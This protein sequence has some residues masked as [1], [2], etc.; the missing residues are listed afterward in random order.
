MMYIYIGGTFLL[1]VLLATIVIPRIIFISYKKRLFDV[2]DARKVHKTPV[3]RLGGL[4]FLPVILISLCIITGIRYYMNEPVALVWSSCLFMRYLFLVAGTTLLYLVGVADDLVGVSYRYKFV[5]QILSASFLPLS[6]LWINDL[7]GLLGLHAIP[8][9]IGM[10]LTVFLVVYITNAINLIDGIDG[11]ASGL[12]CIALGLLIIV[13]TLVGQW[14]HALLASATLG[15]VITFFYYNVFS[16]SG[17]KLFMG[18]AGSLTL[19]YILSFLILHFWMQQEYWEPFKLN[20]NMVTI[21][22]L[23][24]PL[25]DVVRVFYS[26]VRSGRNPFL[27][28]K[29]HIHHKLLRTGMRIRTVMITLLMLSLFLVVANFVLSFYI[30]ATFML[31]FDLIFW[32]TSHLVIN[33][34]I[35]KHEKLTGRKWYKTYIHVPSNK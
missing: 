12:T 22:T 15:V 21:S 4:A 35:V 34:A 25:L 31:L 17:R 1:S 11:L 10:P 9:F 28:D 7:G 3:P 32:C 26:R 33:R 5:V 29:N 20:L 19:G 30:N 23:F 8:A 16:V 6:G 18:D 14:T 27:P 13:C 2:P 24:I